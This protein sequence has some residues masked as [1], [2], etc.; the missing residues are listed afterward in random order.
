MSE[1]VDNR[2]VQLLFDNNKFASGI[3]DSLQK[4]SSF[5]SALDNIG[6]N[7]ALDKIDRSVNKLN[8]NGLLSSVQTVADKFSVLGIMGVTALQNIT[9]KAID[10][11]ERLIKSLS[12]DQI[13]SGM[14]K[15]EQKTGNVQTI[16]N[17]TGDSIDKVNGYLE[18]LQWFSDETS[19]GFTDMTS[20]LATMTAAGGDVEKLIPMITGIANSVAFAGKGAAEFS[21]VMYNLNQSYSQGY[22][23]LMDYK[24]VQNA[25]ATSKQLSQSL[26]NAAK[27]LGMLDEKGRTLKEKGGKGTLVTIEN[28]AQTLNEKWATS[29]VME[30][31]FGEWSKFSEAVYEAV[32]SGEYET[33]ADAISAMANGFSEISVKGFKA[34]QE[35]KTFNEVIDYTKDAVSS[36]WS[37]TFEKIFG[38]YK[39]AKKLWTELADYFYEIFVVPGEE[40]NTILD[41][42]LELGGRNSLVTAFTRSMN[43]IV[44]AIDL[45]KGSFHDIFPKVTGGRLYEWT[46]SLK[47]FAG[48]LQLSARTSEKFGRVFKG[49]FAAADIFLELIRSVVRVLGDFSPKMKTFASRFL[50]GSAS[51]GDLIVQIR[52]YIKENDV[53]YNSIK[54]V[55][56]FIKPAFGGIKSA[57]QS[58]IKYFEDFTGINLHVPTFE[59]LAKVF[60]KIEEKTQVIKGVFG[61]V[62]GV[63]KSVWTVVRDIVRKVNRLL[64][65]RSGLLG[66][67]TAGSVA[68]IGIIA[69]ITKKIMDAGGIVTAIKNL[70]DGINGPIGE[71]FTNLTNILKK[72]FAISSA[73][74]KK[75]LMFAGALGI[76]ALALI[77]IAAIPSE[78]LWV[79]VGALAAISAILLGVAIG[80]ELFAA[81]LNKIDSAKKGLSNFFTSISS[82]IKQRAGLLLISVSLVAIALAIG[83]LAGAL[84]VLAKIPWT[85]LA[86]GLG[87]IIVLLGALAGFIK[88]ISK[89]KI[90]PVTMLLLSG[91]IFAIS[92]SMVVLSVA[93]LMLSAI[94]FWGLAQGVMAIVVAIYALAGAFALFA[95]IGKPL[96]ILAYSAAVFV[97]SAA[98]IALAVALTMLSF[99]QPE[100]LITPLIA[101][102]FALAGLVIAANSIQ[103]VPVGLM[104]LAGA[105]ILFGVALLLITPSMAALASL[106]DGVIG[107][108]VGIAGVMLTFTLA[109]YALSP[110]SGVMILVA[111]AL[112]L[113]GLAVKM[114]ANGIEKASNGFNN[115]IDGVDRLV[116]IKD[117]IDGV[118][119]ALKDALKEIKKGL[120][121]NMSEF[122]KIGFDISSEICFGITEDHKYQ[123]QAVGRF[124]KEFDYEFSLRLDDWHVMGQQAAIGYADGITSQTSYVHD[125]VTYVVNEAISTAKKVQDSHS[126]SKEFAKIGQWAIEGYG[127]GFADNADTAEKAIQKALQGMKYKAKSSI[128]IV[129][130]ILGEYSE[131][132]I[133]PILDLSNIQNGSELIN[134]YL[135]GVNGIDVSGAYNNARNSNPYGYYDDKPRI[136]SWTNNISP[137][138]YIYGA[139]GQD[140]EELADIVM[141]KMEAAYAVK[142]EVYR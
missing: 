124:I 61:T 43:N 132:T 110:V 23:S 87:A 67:I 90:N 100:N 7:D 78:R 30:K 68:K 4:L 109:V 117:N 92:A 25:S 3:K 83:I 74:T 64:F 108:L 125:A 73:N 34:A 46:N 52:D 123:K 9:N 137:N 17:A 136:G 118:G 126:P 55:I 40:R 44:A 37:Q 115:F 51:L 57:I 113:F 28:I 72:F 88:L 60:D 58:A 53:F 104:G 89:I 133:T 14:T 54:K 5:N 135:S 129:E 120:S 32:Q 1:P 91:A 69:I 102:G 116:N 84:W 31:A 13:T 56:D 27:A 42:W 138:F 134:G 131:P 81:K 127:Q 33:A 63:F 139:Q 15:Y 45:V 95:K 71:A 119:Q 18:K 82:F 11:G 130:D 26:I 29:E 140:V 62:I 141:N 59:E 114:V 50:D 39:Q 20:A 22:L 103:Q 80:I 2:I 49:V 12:I 76:M 142:A 99:V 98:M 128:N 70:L 93:L 112:D 35:A 24:S 41:T 121:V 48:N 97:I 10:T 107:A 86:K 75:L 79:A 106:G 8:F 21:R 38:N 111:G 122:R 47:D 94:P 101:L 85:S 96:T 77:G 36:G 19:Y 6:D 105:L 66:G 65:G 16:M